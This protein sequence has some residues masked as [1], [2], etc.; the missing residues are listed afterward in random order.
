MN[1]FSSDNPN[2]K[3]VENNQEE[4]QNIKILQEKNRLMEKEIIQLK[5]QFSEAMKISNNINLLHDEN[6]KLAMKLMQVQTEK[7]DLNQRLILALQ[8]NEDI[9]KKME[10]EIRIAAQKD[11]N[12]IEIAQNEL[13]RVK[14]DN[15]QQIEKQTETVKK[16]ENQQ[17]QLQ[18]QIKL[19]KAE[20]DKLLAAAQKYF[21]ET[22]NNVEEIT[23]ML[24]RSK[25]SHKKPSSNS[26]N[27]QKKTLRTVLAQNDHL[28]KEIE[29]LQRTN[30]SLKDENQ[31]NI[32]ELFQKKQ[33]LLKFQSQVVSLEKKVL[34]F[35]KE[36]SD[37]KTNNMNNINNL[38]NKESI[39]S[40][41]TIE[42]EKQNQQREDQVKITELSISNDNLKIKNNE[43]NKQLNDTITELNTMNEKMKCMEEE[44]N[45][46]KQ[47]YDSALIVHNN[48]VEELKSLRS[49][50][51]QND[52]KNNEINQK[53]DHKIKNQSNVIENLKKSLKFSI[54]EREELEHQMELKKLEIDELKLK[55]QKMSCE[56]QNAQ[57]LQ[58]SLKKEK[59]E[60]SEELSE[61]KDLSPEDVI[62]LNSLK[63]PDFGSEISSQM[64]DIINNENYTHS[65][66]L[67]KIYQVIKK[68]YDS[69]IQEKDHFIEKVFSDAN[70]NRNTLTHFLLD[71]SILIGLNK[72][73]NL[74]EFYKKNGSSEYKDKIQQLIKKIQ[75]LNHEISMYNKLL[76]GFS[77]ITGY[78]NE[79]NEEQFLKHVQFMKNTME[80]QNSKVSKLSKRIKEYQNGTAKRN[81]KNQNLENISNSYNKLKEEKETL[82]LKNNQLEEEISM[83][84]Q[85]MNDFETFNTNNE[86]EKETIIKEYEQRITVLEL[87]FKGKEERLKKQIEESMSHNREINILLGK[88]EA[89]VLELKK[90]IQ[91]QNNQLSNQKEEIEN[92]KK[93]NIDIQERLSSANQMEKTQMKEMYD[94]TI[95]ELN[96]QSQEQRKDI[97]HLSKELGE[98][99]NQIKKLKREGYEEKKKV[100]RAQ[101]DIRKANEDMS[102]H[103]QIKDMKNRIAITEIESNNQK[104]IQN[105][106]E[107]H[108][109]EKQEL[110][111]YFMNK[112]TD[113][114]NTNNIIDEQSFHKMVNRTHDEIQ[115]LKKSEMM[116]RHM[117]NI[118]KNQS[119][120]EGVAIK[121]INI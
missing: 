112:F 107:R 32:N 97:E 13:K 35:N 85:R 81:I 82:C 50:L 6:Q 98:A 9:Q 110:I 29:S 113:L 120:E 101:N 63:Y 60:I 31:K 64:D 114:F 2:S 1:D 65:L 17:N 68:Y 105:L 58:E 118:P 103:E 10:F 71:I 42:I 14:E 39:V 57:N 109:L 46:V 27:K 30:Q 117:L 28:Q 62:P 59:D 38:E 11:T 119:L 77:K 102:R 19:M 61:K 25:N 5:N 70:E 43:L 87:D 12:T 15:K 92:L 67:Q 96:N 8:Q 36:I 22:F 53:K 74:E 48:D 47:Q 37:I 111:S 72:P 66:K 49:M 73:V 76:D 41:T 23:Y 121:L 108:K 44:K 18:I 3:I 45:R 34:S 21:N 51:H 26:N 86:K 84:H 33:E 20:E 91:D 7:E 69:Q 75:S 24:N 79:V 52:F 106:V 115:K 4:N 104:K 90:T 16:L 54:H 95:F 89:M 40:P 55:T 80:E 93:N 78:N 100:I 99:K 83:L 94:K 116:I 56:L 88:N